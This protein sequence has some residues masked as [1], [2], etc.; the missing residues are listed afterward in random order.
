MKQSRKKL[1]GRGKKS[2][3][4]ET[5]RAA[6]GGLRN[7]GL[8]KRRLWLFRLLSASFPF[9]FLLLAEIAFR[10]VP[11]LNVDRD[12]Y[13]NISPVSVFTRTTDAAGREYYNVTHPDILNGSDVHILVKKPA[14][15]IRIFCL[16]ESASAGWPH[17]AAETFSAYLQQALQTAFPGKQIEV[18]NLSAHGFAAYR[19]KYILDEALKLQPDAV[20]VWTGNNEF[21]EDRN[22]T[23]PPNAA[24]AFLSARLRTVQWLQSIF[25]SRSNLS[26]K[27]LKDVSQFF[28]AKIHQQSLRLRADPAQF[29]QVQNHY[30]ESL[31]HMISASQRYRVPMVL[32]TVPVNLR[33]W[34]PTVSTNRLGGDQLEQWQTLFNQARRCLIQSNYQAGIQ[35]MNRAIAMEGEDAESYF[36]LGRLLEADGQKTAAW[37]AYSEARDKDYNPFRALGSFN[38]AIRGLARENQ[39]HGVYLLDLDRIFAGASKHA[40]PGFDLF[41]DYV[42]PTKPGNLLVAKNAFDLMT[43]DGVLKDKPAVDQF[44][45]HDLPD[46]PNGKPYRDEDDASL[47]GTALMMAVENHQIETV[48]RETETLVERLTGHHIT[49]PGDLVSANNLPPEIVERYRIFW[50]YLDVQ[51][52]TLMNLP[53]GKTELEDAKRGVD[54]YYKKWFPLGRY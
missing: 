3:E 45:Y 26:G 25:A 1:G 39:D 30:R 8:S 23:A 18:A 35:A 52:R 29:A 21:L 49:W 47:Q 17:P 2:V 44:I 27:E 14:N 4:A 7:G 16:G 10:V 42:H 37:D 20:I 19:V 6:S 41:L 12:P 38:D 46:G 31:E 51:R 48:V 34:L 11:G 36:W 32:C 28:W 13:L 53:V 43:R 54:D 40:A 50:N 5:P 22:Y 24:I 33:D 9:V 15:T